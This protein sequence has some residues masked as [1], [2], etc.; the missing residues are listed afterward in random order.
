ML[1]LVIPHKD[2]TVLNQKRNFLALSR[3]ASNS[4]YVKE[5]PSPHL[6]MHNQ[7]MVVNLPVELHPEKH[8]GCELVSHLCGPFEVNER[9]DP[10]SLGFHDIGAPDRIP[11]VLFGENHLE[12][13]AAVDDINLHQNLHSLGPTYSKTR[14]VNREGANGGSPFHKVFRECSA[15]ERRIRIQYRS[16]RRRR[17]NHLPGATTP[18]NM[19]G[20]M[21]YCVKNALA[22]N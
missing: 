14:A 4:A 9:T 16:L 7:P 8:S 10:C 17:S 5:A 21:K 15:I 2:R 1:H 11:K 20:P 12:H 18:I 22:Y 19:K 6:C 3:P 13:V